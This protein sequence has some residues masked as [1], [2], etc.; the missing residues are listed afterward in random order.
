MG[1]TPTIKELE[2]KEDEFKDY[3]KKLEDRLNKETG[4]AAGEIDRSRK[5]FYGT[6][7]YDDAKSLLSGRSNDFQ[8]KSELSLANLKAIIDA[9]AKAVFAGSGES[10]GRTAQVPTG[11]TVHPQTAGAVKEVAAKSIG[12][13]AAE[14]GALEFYIAGKVFDVISSVILSFGASVSTQYSNEFKQEP[15]GYGMQLFVTTAAD[16]YRS[17]A[18][19]NNEEI[20]EYLFVY[21]VWFSQKQAEQEA[22]ISLVKL[23]TDQIATFEGKEEQLLAQLQNNTITAEQYGSASKIYETLTLESRKKL[24]GLRGTSTD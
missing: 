4:D 8:H 14:M 7:K 1:H 2:A 18:F 12:A 10:P 5:D 3:L 22:D 6:N 24:E 13:G 21:Q 15:L 23:Y 9:I 20:Y 16:S 17:A 19:F 11:V